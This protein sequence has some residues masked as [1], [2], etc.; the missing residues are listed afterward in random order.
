MRSEIRRSRRRHNKGMIALLGGIVAVFVI[1][2]DLCLDLAG[3]GYFADADR[4]GRKGF[5]VG[6]LYALSAPEMG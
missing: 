5:A 4:F 6:F 2:P 1:A 3:F